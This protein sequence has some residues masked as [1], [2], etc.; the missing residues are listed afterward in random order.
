MSVG[1]PE[2]NT[3]AEKWTFDEASKFLDEAIELSQSTEY[4]FIGE[5]AKKQG[6]YHHVYNY[7]IEKFPNLTYKFNQIKANCESNCFYNGKKGDIVPSLAIMNL[8]SNHG[9]TDRVQNDHTT[10]GEKIEFNLK[11]YTDEEL[12][13]IAELQRKGGVSK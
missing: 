2:N 9:W 3:N 8:K 1:A 6:S 4:D 10:Q 5:V 12:R 13:L 11:N 7:I